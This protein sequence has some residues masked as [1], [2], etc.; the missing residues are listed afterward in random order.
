MKYHSDMQVEIKDALEAVEAIKPFL[1]DEPKA[2][3]EIQKLLC[4]S[5]FERVLFEAAVEEYI[6]RIEEEI[7]K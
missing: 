3:E 2:R 7:E 5:G 6:E 1:K 4:Q